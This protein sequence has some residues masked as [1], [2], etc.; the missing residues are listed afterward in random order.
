MFYVFLFLLFVGC[1]VI[2]YQPY[3][4][5]VNLSAEP[6]T[7]NPITAV[8][9]Y[10]GAVNKYV[11]E[12]LLRRDNKTL[13]FIPSLATKYYISNDGLV[14]TFELRK[15]VYWHDGVEFTADDVV[16]SFKKIMDPKVDAPHLRVYYQDVKKV[17]KLGK[18]KVR[19]IFKRRYFK[20][21]EFAGG[22][23]IVPKHIYQYGDFN[24]HKNNRHPIGTGPYRFLKWETGKRIILVRNEKYWGEKPEIKKIIFKIIP[25]SAIAL[26]VLKKKE[27]DVS[28]IRAIQWVRQTNSLKFL[29]NF[30]KLKYYTPNYNFI[31]YNLRKKFFQDRRV[32]L[33]LTYLVDREKI[34]HKLL[35][36]LGV[37]T[38]GPFYV[39]GS[40]YDKTIKPY[41]YS[42][43][44][45]VRLLEEAGWIDHD[46]DG[47]RDKD[48]TPFKFTFM[49]SSGSNFA[50][51]LANIIKEEF[52]KYGIVVDIV[53]Y[54]WAI[55]TRN[56]TSH[57]FD[58]TTLGWAFGFEQD[59]YQVWHSSQA[60][61][62]SNFVGYKNKEVDRLIEEARV[63]LSKKKRDEIFKKIHRIIHKDQPYTFLFCTPNLVAVSRRFENVRAY[64]LGLDFREWKIKKLP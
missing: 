21:L 54:E 48:G 43:D 44:K 12:T 24:S 46:G 29:K 39:F 63:T 26:Q 60:E 35:F 64:P 13:S 38:T 56:L 42:P 53:R 33:A 62:G 47:I 25:E 55:F 32:R 22:M 31:A 15:G 5:R 34:L 6:D 10:E 50:R 18:Y 52:K 23:P 9:V 51:K 27:I 61:K 41:R 7:L 59:P 40:S 58:A 16:F 20:A 3:A 19:F 49:I 45:A 37:I 28:G 4:L 1:N 11:M 36:N 17:E 30:M 2:P 57:S 8:D 14:F